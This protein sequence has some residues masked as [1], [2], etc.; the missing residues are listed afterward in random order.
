MTS[1]GMGKS[2]YSPGSGG[3]ATRSVSPVGQT[4]DHAGPEAAH[5]SRSALPANEPE[6]MMLGICG[7]SFD[8]LSMSADLQFALASRLVAD[9]G[10]NGSPEYALIW[11]SWAMPSGPQICRL[12]ALGRRISD[13]GCGGWP[14]PMTSANHESGRYVIAL[15]AGHVARS[16]AGKYLAGWPTPNVPSGGRSIAHAELRGNTAY[17]NGKKVQ[18]GLEAVAKMAGWP[19]PRASDEK[20]TR[21]R[22]GA[23]KEAARKGANNDLGSAA[24]LS[25][26]STEKRGALAPEFSRWLMGYPPEWASC[27]PTGTPSSLK[28]RPRSCKPPRA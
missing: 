5:A 11:K 12:R 21:T 25:H 15:L 24:A 23:V 26:A 2:T 22:E 20:N 3:G 8:G 19:T 9:L 6:Q 10:A 27:A 13:K 4:T 28:S 16:E 17:H 18:I 1:E 7:Q 14:T